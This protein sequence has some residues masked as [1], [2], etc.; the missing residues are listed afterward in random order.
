VGIQ[1]QSYITKISNDDDDDDDDDDDTDL[2]LASS[3]GSSPFSS[4]PQDND[5]SGV[6]FVAYGGP[7]DDEDD[8]ARRLLGSGGVDAGD[9]NTQ[10]DSTKGFFEE[11]VTMKMQQALA[12]QAMPTPPAHD[13]DEHARGLQVPFLMDVTFENCKFINNKQGPRAQGGIPLLGV[14]NIITRFNPTTVRNCTFKG[15]VF[16]G[17]DG[18]QNGFAIQSLGADLTV[19]RV[20]LIDNSFIGFGP[21]QAFDGARFTHE[22]TFT[23]TDEL[24]FCEFAAESD[25]AV[26]SSLADLQ[27]IPKDRATCLGDEPIDIG[28]ST[29][30]PTAAPSSGTTS[31]L[32]G[33][34]L[35]LLGTGLCAYLP[36]ILL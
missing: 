14:I 28:T 2:S 36:T 5:N 22:N 3:G 12:L 17:S 20:C 29:T 10:N 27:C 25:S 9:S 7:D 13:P 16:D 6:L 24:S 26:P 15:N 31:T 19:E 11:W 21:I 30:V 33:G 8:T 35:L 34:L 1:S 4:R 32:R 18:S 23:T